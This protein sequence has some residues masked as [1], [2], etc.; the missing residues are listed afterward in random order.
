MFGDSASYLAY[1]PAANMPAA[2]RNLGPNTV[3]VYFQT[4][5]RLLCHLVNGEWICSAQPKPI[6]PPPPPGPSFD[7]WACNLAG[8][9]VYDIARVVVKFAIDAGALTWL[10]DLATGI[11][12]RLL[13]V[14]LPEEY[15]LGGAFSTFLAGWLTA[16]FQPLVAGWSTALLDDV[17]WSKIHCKVYDAIE[18]S[19]TDLHAAMAAAATGIAAITGINT[20]VAS[21]IGL[22][23]QSIGITSFLD[24]PVSGLVRQYNCTSCV[25][26][27]TGGPTPIRQP[28]FDL[29]VQDVSTSDAFVDT[30]TFLDGVVGGT[31]PNATYTPP[32]LVAGS[33]ISIAASG[34]D[35]T[36][37]ASGGGGPTIVQVTGDYTMLDGDDIVVVNGDGVTGDIT[38]TLPP[39]SGTVKPRTIFP[40]ISPTGSI[41]LAAHGTDKIMDLGQMSIVQASVALQGTAS[42][43]RDGTPWHFINEPT[44]VSLRGPVWTPAE[45]SPYNTSS[46]GYWGGLP[47]QNSPDSLMGEITELED[48]VTTGSLQVVSVTASAAI[49]PSTDCVLANATGGLITLT[50]P[51]PTTQHKQITVRKTDASANPVNV[52]PHGSELINGGSTPISL[53]PANNA[54]ILITTGTDWWTLLY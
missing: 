49:D 42:T 30:L 39:Y 43:W 22:F 27:G 53:G 37:S 4:D 51:N 1:G 34:N 6:P 9:I 13:A 5:T 7:Q 16:H 17:L 44:L 19:P 15:I 18:A 24:F 36:I 26:T 8:Y 45:S 25:S 54:V 47:W 46:T 12:L 41:I 40:A 28:Q 52:A 21:G 20:D 23:L 38:I 33:G 2:P 35:R 31:S 10:T 3:A 48:A 29:I 50:L 14:L 32:Q 11:I